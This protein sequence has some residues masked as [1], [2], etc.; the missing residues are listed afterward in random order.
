MC[1]PINIVC[2]ARIRRKRRSNDRAT[3]GADREITYQLG[4]INC[5]CTPDVINRPRNYFSRCIYIIRIA[6][7]SYSFVDV[8]PRVVFFFSLSLS[9][10]SFIYLFFPYGRR[11]TVVRSRVIKRSV[12]AGDQ[13]MSTRER[14]LRRICFWLISN[15]PY[16]RAK[17][18]FNYNL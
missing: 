11:R 6:H 18:R 8:L 9:P 5:V 7:V 16:L 3:I 2:R 10:L 17:S 1:L 12:I 15:A 13:D 14:A 4:N